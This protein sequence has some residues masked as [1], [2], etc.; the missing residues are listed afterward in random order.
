MPPEETA[1]VRLGTRD[2]ALWRDL[3]PGGQEAPLFDAPRE[4]E[5]LPDEN[6]V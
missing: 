2:L 4:R 1:S 6:L 3:G 5:V